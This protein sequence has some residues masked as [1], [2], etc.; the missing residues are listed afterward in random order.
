MTFDELFSEHTLTDAERRE[1]VYFLAAF[2]MRKTI[3]RLL[4]QNS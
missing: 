3:E 4:P 1:L 2:R